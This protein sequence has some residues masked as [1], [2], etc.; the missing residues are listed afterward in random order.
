MTA[1]MALPTTV[2][3]I[4]AT[5]ATATISRLGRCTVEW[6]GEGTGDFD[7]D[8][9]GEHQSRDDELHEDPKMLPHWPSGCG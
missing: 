4:S 1:S 8:Q 5:A 7:R 3:R 2:T 6:L 9:G